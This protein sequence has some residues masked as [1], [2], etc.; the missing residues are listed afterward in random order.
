MT[1]CG[2]QPHV[3]GQSVAAPYSQTE[4][5]AAEHHGRAEQQWDRHEGA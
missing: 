1:D 4:H 5:Q 3:H 2:E